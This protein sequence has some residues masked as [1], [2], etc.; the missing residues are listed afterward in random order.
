MISVS[1]ILGRKNGEKIVMI[2]AY[3]ALFAKLFDEF[4]DIILVGDSL[5]MSFGGHKDTLNLSLEAMIYH[6]SAVKRATK[7][8]LVVADMPFGT[9]VSEK[10]ALNS[11][12][13]LYKKA[14]VDAVKI[15]G[16]TNIAP[17]IRRLSDEGIAVMAHIGLR[18]QQS[19]IEGGYKIKGRREEDKKMLFD[20]LAAVTDA[21]AFCVVLEGTLRSLSD[22][23]SKKSKIPTIG[24]GSSANCDGQ[25]LVWSD[26]LGFY[27]EFKPKFVKHYLNGANLVRE[28]VQKYAEEVRAGVFPS[29]EFEYEK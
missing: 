7:H 25:V 17:V 4:V 23:I 10:K 1:N 11:A 3:D 15:E 5:N 28:A 22:E 8:A 24:I 2:T 21:G 6:A 18:P 9:T 20:D 26:M 29:K 14:G 16:G 13:K 19:R 27:D 12:I